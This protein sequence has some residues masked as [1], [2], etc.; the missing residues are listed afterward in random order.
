MF[1]PTYIEK[2]RRHIDKID[3]LIGSSRGQFK[4]ADL[5]VPRYFFKIGD[6]FHH[7]RLMEKD[8]VKTVKEIIGQSY[9]SAGIPFEEYPIDRCIIIPTEE[10]FI[11]GF[12]ATGLSFRPELKG[13]GPE[14][15][16]D[17]Y[18]EITTKK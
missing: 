5:E 1:K 16:L 12:E 17:Y 4:S 10:Q 13:K 9:L 15:L 14:A 11:L 2:C 3:Y 18:I 7:P 6:F 8:E